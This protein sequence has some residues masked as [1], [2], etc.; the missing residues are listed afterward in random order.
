[1]NQQTMQVQTSPQ[2]KHCKIYGCV[3]DAITVPYGSGRTRGFC[4]VH[5][6]V[7]TL[8][9]GKFDCQY[10]I[11]APDQDPN[12]MSA[13]TRA[14][15]QNYTSRHLCTYQKRHCAWGPDYDRRM[16]RCASVPPPGPMLDSDNEG[17]YNDVLQELQAF[18]PIPMTTPVDAQAASQDQLAAAP[19]QPLPII[20]AAIQALASP[21]IPRSQAEDLPQT[22]VDLPEGRWAVKTRR[23]KITVHKYNC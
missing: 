14:E 4:N 20:P 18:Q 5:H 22:T 23:K 9:D 21:S 12:W 16:G 10:N 7:L 8:P 6:R 15:R 3:L 17:D 13:N 1:M 11:S 19:Q 2:V